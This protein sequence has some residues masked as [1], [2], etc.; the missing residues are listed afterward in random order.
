MIVKYSKKF[1]Y[2][3]FLNEDIGFDK[4]IPDNATEEEMIQAVINLNRIATEAYHRMN[5]SLPTLITDYNSGEQRVQ[6]IQIEPK[7]RTIGV[8]VEDIE[9]CKDLKTLDTY[10]WL[11]KEP[12]LKEAYDKRLKELS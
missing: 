4:S 8:L 1:P 9:S 2:A 5:P 6:E 7:E 10:K 11:L 12:A 3:P